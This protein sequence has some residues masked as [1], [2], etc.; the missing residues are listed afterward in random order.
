MVRP[1]LLIGFILTTLFYGCVTDNDGVPKYD[2]ENSAK[3][4]VL[5]QKMTVAKLKDGSIIFGDLIED[6]TG[7]LVLKTAKAGKV[8]IDKE[9]LADVTKKRFGII[10]DTRDGISYRWLEMGGLAWMAENLMYK[11]NNSWAPDDKE[12]Y[13][14]QYGRLYS[15]QDASSTC[16]ENWR[17][18]T[19]EEWQNIEIEL[20][21]EPFQAGEKGYRGKKE[22]DLIKPNGNSLFT[23][24][25][26]GARYDSRDFRVTGRGGYYW[27]AT[28][29]LSGYAWARNIHENKMQ[30]ARNY[31]DK[32]QGFSV[33]CVCE[34]E[35]LK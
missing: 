20:G 5:E 4:E 33:R 35:K 32:S 1:L 2:P 27:T 19:D 30:I 17:L 31:F 28:A 10:S 23:L 14:K 25:Y 9:H 13:V 8:R 3:T 11:S 24:N 34:L 7:F 22:G 29:Y 12:K 21:M 16:P 6:G 15:W 26:G 18:P